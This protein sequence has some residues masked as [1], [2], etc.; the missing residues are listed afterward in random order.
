M[1]AYVTDRSTPTVVA[2]EASNGNSESP[3]TPIDSPG[4]STFISKD[5]T[6]PSS[7]EDIRPL[8]KARPRKTQNVKKKKTTTAILTD[9]PIKN[10]LKKP[11]HTSW[12][13]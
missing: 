11:Q 1:G 6:H 3:N 12:S 8:P 7:L 13:K 9:T 4:P 5:K 2:A 10:A